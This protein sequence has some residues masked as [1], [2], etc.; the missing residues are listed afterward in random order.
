[1]PPGPVKFHKNAS[2]ASNTVIITTKW[3]FDTY[4]K[5]FLKEKS[6]VFRWGRVCVDEA[7]L[8]INA[9]S[10]AISIVRSLG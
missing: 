9:P 10:R 7:H 5:D 6:L 2:N 8:D 4:V 3:G 1:M